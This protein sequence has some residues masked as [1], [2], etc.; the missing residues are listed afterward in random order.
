MEKPRFI[1]IYTES[2]PNPNSQKFVLN[3]Y[4]LENMSF[5]FPS[6]EGT[7]NCPIAKALFD[8]FDF[9][10]GV[11]IASNFITI[12]KSASS[13]WF[14]INTPVK[15]FIKNYIQEEKPLFLEGI[16]QEVAKEDIKENVT[17]TP[18]DAQIKA[19]LN[20][21][22]R[23]AVESDG[24]AIS[25]HSFDE[26]VVKVELKGACS[27]CPSSTVTLKSGIEN[28]LKRMVPGVEKVEA[29]EL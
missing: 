8:Q 19:V 16:K 27:G 21:Y 18:T 10:E 13:D 7:E 15:E 11:F 12:T 4:L 26:G 3:F 22:V 9:I 17:E 5:D 25:F 28:L 6:A 29:V 23:P 24:G 1:N 14:E 2:S 20:D